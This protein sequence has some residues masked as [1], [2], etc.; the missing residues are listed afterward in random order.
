MLPLRVQVW[1]RATGH[2]AR[3]SRALAGKARVAGSRRFPDVPSREPAPTLVVG[4]DGSDAAPRR[5]R[6]RRP[7]GW[8]QRPHVRRPRVRASAGLPWLSR[9]RSR[10]LRAA[11]RER[12]CFATYR[13]RTTCWPGR[14][15]DGADRRPASLGDAATLRVPA[16]PMRSSSAPAGSG[17]CGAA[18]ERLTRVAAH[19]RP[20]TGRDP[21]RRAH[22]RAMTFGKWKMAR[23]R[24]TM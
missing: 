1:A 11:D 19:R 18:G 20:P 9:V 16:T 6:V 5:A 7:S 13:S 15:L 24:P 21:A 23:T 2:V 12:L 17:A 4:Y 22:T 10:S 3:A 14:V 8:T